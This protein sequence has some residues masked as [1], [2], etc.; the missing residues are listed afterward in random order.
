M[1]NGIERE[2]EREIDKDSGIKDLREAVRTLSERAEAA[3][4]K[5]DRAIERAEAAE[6]KRDR[7][8]ERVDAL[9]RDASAADGTRALYREH[10]ETMERAVV[11]LSCVVARQRYGVTLER[12]GED[13]V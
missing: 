1:P 13:T 8:Q 12:G 2:I 6:D 11:A 4:D 9:E 3:E 10:A 5:R 7:L